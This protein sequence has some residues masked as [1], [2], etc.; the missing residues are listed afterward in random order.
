MLCKEDGGRV[1]ARGVV[2]EVGQ[3]FLVAAAEEVAVARTEEV[4]VEGAAPEELFVLHFEVAVLIEVLFLLS[5]DMREGEENVAEAVG[6]RSAEDG[7]ELW[8]RGQ[9][10]RGYVEAMKSEKIRLMAKLM[11]TMP[12]CQKLA[13]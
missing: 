7:D 6:F 11:R 1:G 8:E 4:S 10:W 3:A 12:V 2:D 13:L 5:L 9:V